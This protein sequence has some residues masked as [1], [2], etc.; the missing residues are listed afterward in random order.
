[1]NKRPKSRNPFT[2]LAEEVEAAVDVWNSHFDR[3]TAFDIKMSPSEYL[4]TKGPTSSATATGWGYLYAFQLGPFTKVGCTALSAEERKLGYRTH[5]PFS[6][7]TRLS[8]RVTGAEVRAAE[9]YAHF[10]LSDFCYDSE[11]FIIPN[12]FAILEKTFKAAS[13]M[14]RLLR[15]KDRAEQNAIRYRVFLE[16]ERVKKEAKAAALCAAADN[17]SIAA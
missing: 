9:K 10:L 2:R 13:E 16:N 17:P 14:S 12:G 1:M 7:K 8:V 4:E 15:E 6:L 3:L 11:W 5:C